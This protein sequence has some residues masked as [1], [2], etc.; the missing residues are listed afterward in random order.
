MRYLGGSL[1][2]CARTFAPLALGAI[3]K[4]PPTITHRSIVIHMERSPT[5]F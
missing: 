2:D 1:V 5:G 4:L 3:G